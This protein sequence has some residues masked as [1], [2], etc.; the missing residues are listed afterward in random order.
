MNIDQSLIILTNHDKSS[1]PPHEGNDNESE[2]MVSFVLWNFGTAACTY[3]EKVSVCA[4]NFL[5]HA[6][7]KGTFKEYIAL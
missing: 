5:L 4:V 3:S 7:A 2:A 6:A 1:I